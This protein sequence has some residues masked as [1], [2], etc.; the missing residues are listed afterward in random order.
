MNPDQTSRIPKGDSN[1]EIKFIRHS[2]AGYKSL[3]EIVGSSNPDRP[4]EP[5]EQIF[6][7]LT[8]AGIELAEQEAE[9]IFSAMDPVTDAIFIASSDQSRALE[10]AQIYKNIAKEKGFTIIAPEHDRNP[11]AEQMNEKE[12]RVVKSLSL[13]PESS[14]WGALFSPPAQL[15][16]IHWEGVDPAVRLQWEN[17]RQVVLQDDKGNWGAN[18]AHYSD[19]LKERGLLSDTQS[20]ARELFETQ[21]V[22][23]LR[24]AR[25]GAK[26]SAGGFNGKRIKIIV[27]GH[28]NYVAKA[29]EEYFGEEGIQNCE[30][31]DVRV[32]S[33]DSIEMERRGKLAQVLHPQNRPITTL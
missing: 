1:G 26:K 2:R 7:D 9:K 16:P 13:Q 27:F 17:A 33:D 20:T 23:L 3:S 8:E 18:F 15:G 19:V 28:E 25:F 6:P 29:L 14:L 22:Q 10:T 24:L 4:V 12:I 32:N 11:L 31:V 5:K 30:V 21:F